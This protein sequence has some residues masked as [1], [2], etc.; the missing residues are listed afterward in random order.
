MEGT[1]EFRYSSRGV[2]GGIPELGSH[3]NHC[4]TNMISNSL[5]CIPAM[6]VK[7]WYTNTS[8][9]TMQTCWP[10]IVLQLKKQ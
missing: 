5:E 8:L 2:E 7:V 4:V 3:D 6:Q 10:P 9:L 1:R